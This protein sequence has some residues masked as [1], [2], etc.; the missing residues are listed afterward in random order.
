M[1]GLNALEIRDRNRDDRCDHHQHDSHGKAG[2]DDET[3]QDLSRFAA[4]GFRRFVIDEKR[5]R[6]D[7]QWQHT[8]ENQ[9]KARDDFFDARV[10]QAFVQQKQKLRDLREE[11]RDQKNRP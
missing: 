11:N 4:Q 6:S 10:F 3:F 7:N 5:R 8:H 2:R 1:L 9:R